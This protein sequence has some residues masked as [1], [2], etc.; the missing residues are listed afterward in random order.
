MAVS[1][2][3]TRIS[4]TLHVNN[5]VASSFVN[6]VAGP[7]RLNISPCEIVR[8]KHEQFLSD[9]ITLPQGLMIQQLLKTCADP[10]VVDFFRDPLR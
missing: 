3:F 8:V 10:K 9:E 4:H 5:W 6:L 1:K 7:G 2:I